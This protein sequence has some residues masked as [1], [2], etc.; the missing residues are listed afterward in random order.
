MNGAATK[1]HNAASVAEGD[2]EAPF[3]TDLAVT[4][5]LAELGAQARSAGPSS[6]PF[7]LAVPADLPALVVGGPQSVRC[8]TQAFQRSVRSSALCLGLWDPGP[9]VPELLSAAEL[10]AFLGPLS[11]PHPSPSEWKL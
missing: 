10:P 4:P 11:L 5:S 8:L 1:S 2:T 3:P 9:G 7:L 6:T